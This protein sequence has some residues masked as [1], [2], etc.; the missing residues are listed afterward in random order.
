MTISELL[1]CA[2]IVHTKFQIIDRQFF[3][4]YDY[5]V[6]DSSIIYYITHENNIY[7]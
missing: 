3:R 6:Y 5:S 1:Y 2:L 7:I 4:I